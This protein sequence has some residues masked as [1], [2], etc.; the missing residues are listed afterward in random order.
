MDNLNLY[1]LSTYQQ[2]C[3]ELGQRLGFDGSNKNRL[4]AGL[5]DNPQAQDYF[6]SE[7]P[8]VAFIVRIIEFF[9]RI[10][11]T[12]AVIMFIIAGFQL[13][14]SGGNQQKLDEAKDLMKYAAIGLIVTFASIIIVM[15]IQSIFIDAQTP[16]PPITTTTE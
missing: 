7:S 9:T 10:I 12:I 8:I 13:M 6:Q 1:C 16:P 3:I 5:A 2:D 14:L 4:I 15:F 11:G